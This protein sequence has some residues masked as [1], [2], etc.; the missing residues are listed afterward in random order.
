[1]ESTMASPS[2]DGV[3]WLM[4]CAVLVG[5]PLPPGLHDG[6]TQTGFQPCIVSSLFVEETS[7][8]S[9]KSKA[10]CATDSVERS[11]PTYSPARILCRIFIKSP[12]HD[13]KY[14]R[15]RS[16]DGAFLVLPF[17]ESSNPDAT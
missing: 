16:P 8:E 17:G 10:V 3:E 7:E 12:N 15:R 13:A 6:N 14:G 2:F 9:E 11:T 1:M 4:V 5:I